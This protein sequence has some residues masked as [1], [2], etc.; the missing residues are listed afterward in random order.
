MTPPFDG[1]LLV[2]FGGPVPGCCGAR[3]PCPGEATCFVEGVLGRNP[4]RA[5]RVEEVAAHYR[6][7]GGF[8]PFQRGTEVQAAALEGS[9]RNLGFPLPV[10][11]A[12]RHWTPYV[13]DVLAGLARS[14]R[15]R[16][17]A[18]VMAPHQSSVSWDWYLKVVAEGLEPLGASAP[19]VAFLDPWWDHPGFVEACAA[20]VAEVLMPG[21][22]LLFTA[23]AIPEALARTSPYRKQ[24]RETAEAV[25]GRLGMPFSLAYQSGP[26]EASAPWTGPDIVEHLEEHAAPGKNF[27]TAPVG[28]LVDNVEVLYDLDVAA[29]KAAQAKG[30]GFARAPSVGTH[31]AFIG[32]LATRIAVRCKG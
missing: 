3:Q 30:A 2:A 18:V 24:F 9:L 22:E 7:L 4:G 8:S 17:L 20:R 15:R 6:H 13:K 29:R 11:C 5:D 19:E 21:A 10:F 26:G 31:R 27:V 32:M 16:V 23:H 28:F 25:A 12:Y 14:G 1:I